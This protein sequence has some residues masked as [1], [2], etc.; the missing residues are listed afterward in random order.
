MLNIKEFIFLIVW[1]FFFKI[2]FSQSFK[3]V[4]DFFP[5]NGYVPDSTTAIKIAEAV[6]LPIYG[7]GIYK[8]KPFNVEL[9]GDTIWH[10]YGSTKKSYYEINEKGDTIA[11]HLTSGGIPHIWLRKSDTKIIKV[12]HSK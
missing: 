8:N 12:I 10:V 3:E 7:K 11:L 5:E 9:I 6:W 1:L 2:S 4:N